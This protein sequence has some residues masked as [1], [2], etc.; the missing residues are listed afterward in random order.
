M[1]EIVCQW[2]VLVY[3]YVSLHFRVADSAEAQDLATIHQ[4]AHSA[5]LR[6]TLPLMTM[7][8]A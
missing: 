3:R 5:V 8:I 4:D 2:K 1:L 7:Y 6:G